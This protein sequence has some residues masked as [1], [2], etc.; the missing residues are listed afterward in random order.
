M[1]NYVEEVKVKDLPVVAVG[2]EGQGRLVAR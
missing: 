1:P 2:A